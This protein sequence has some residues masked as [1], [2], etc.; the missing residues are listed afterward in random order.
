VEWILDQLVALWGEGASWEQDARSHPHEAQL[1]KLDVSKVNARLD[2]RPR[3]SLSHT[4]DM[5]VD[6][7]RAW[8]GGENMRRYTLQQIASYEDG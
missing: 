6:W 2:W 8:L 3:W 7:H 4:L 5:I 1:L